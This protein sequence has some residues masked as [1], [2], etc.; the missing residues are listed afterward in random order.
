MFLQRANEGKNDLW[1]YIITILV[2]IAGAVLGGIPLLLVLML[3]SDGKM[4]PTDLQKAMEGGDFS[5]F[6]I[7]ANTFLVLML[8]Q[9]VIAFFLLWWMIVALHKKTLTGVM[10][11]RFR[12]D[13][14]R[15]W[16]GFAVWGG[17]MMAFEIVSYAMNPENY[18]WQFELTSFIPL[19][20]IALILLPIQT[21]AEEL[22]M[23]GYLMQGIS[24]ISQYRW[25]PLVITS[26][27]FGLLH[28]SNPEVSKY[29]FYTM[30]LGYISIGLTLGI[31]T[32]MDDGMELALGVH[33]ANNIFGALFVTFEGSV[34]AT[35]ALFKVKEINPLMANIFGIIACVLFILLMANILGWKD[36]T[37][38][39]GKIK[40]SE[41]NIILAEE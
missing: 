28:G 32:L 22:L 30:M 6:G 33:A 38:L 35:P 25:I 21:S 34:L 14:K 39:Y 10:T 24:L 11:A 19:L 7:S 2:V 31:I 37:K 27:V 1:R 5:E 29:G 12:L 41:E 26:L 4:S 13:W 8:L 9:F 15:I 17:M 3:N 40:K 16:L 20:V 23:R 18:I 36:W